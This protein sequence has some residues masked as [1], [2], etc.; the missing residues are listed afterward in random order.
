MARWLFCQSCQ[1]WSKSTAA[2]SGDGSC[3]LCGNPFIKTESPQ[4]TIPI[5]TAVPS[6]DVKNETEMTAQEPPLS[7]PGGVLHAAGKTQKAY[8]P[9][10]RS[11]DAIE[12]SAPAEIIPDKT[13]E[14]T[15]TFEEIETENTDALFDAP[16]P[17]DSAQDTLDDEEEVPD[18]H[19]M[20]ENSESSP[21]QVTD[22]SKVSKQHESYMELR[23]RKRRPR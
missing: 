8:F 15:E 13:M 11:V 16:V 3:P 12:A 4:D 5:H 17:P 2:L 18:I 9:D 20:D 22:L 14:E 21:A 23:R 19:E 7:Q 10:E 1:Q 6:E